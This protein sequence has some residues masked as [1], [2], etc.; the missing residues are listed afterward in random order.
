MDLQSAVNKFIELFFFLNS[1]FTE[2]P[3]V[4]ANLYIRFHTHTFPLIRL[5]FTFIY[6]M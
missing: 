3:A 6:Y 5:A 1:D 4:P 2:C